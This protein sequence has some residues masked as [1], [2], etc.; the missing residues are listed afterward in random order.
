MKKICVFWVMG[1]KILGGVATA[2]TH[3]VFKFKKSG[4]KNNFMHFE[5]RFAFQNAKKYIFS[6]NLKKSRFH[7]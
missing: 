7:Q 5:R 1:L 2:A 3:M 4:K 6:E